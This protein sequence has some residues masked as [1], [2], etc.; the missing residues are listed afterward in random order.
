MNSDKSTNRGGGPK[1]GAS[2]AG[3]DH[4]KFGMTTKVLARIC[5]NCGICPFAARRPD[6]AIDRVMRWH[7]TWCPAWNA[8]TKVYGE[9]LLT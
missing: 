7:R 9:K 4:S 6:S 2:D 3:I 5:H 1:V 8:H